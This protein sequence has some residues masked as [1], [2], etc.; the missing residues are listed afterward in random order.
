MSFFHKFSVIYILTERCFFESWT[1]RNWISSKSGFSEEI[2]E[3]SNSSESENELKTSE[4]IDIFNRNLLRFEQ[5]KDSLNWN[6]CL[7]DYC[8]HCLSCWREISSCSEISTSFKTW[9]FSHNILIMLIL[10]FK[11]IKTSLELGLVWVY[12]KVGHILLYFFALAI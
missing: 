11:E 7:K 12:A 4:N 2:V 8:E 3:E 10:S 5:E 6:D 9:L 1:L